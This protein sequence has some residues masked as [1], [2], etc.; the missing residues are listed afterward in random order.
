MYLP[1]VGN[2]LIEIWAKL[3]GNGKH[4][5]LVPLYS[6]TNKNIPTSP[7]FTRKQIAKHHHYAPLPEPET[8]LV[9]VQTTQTLFLPIN[10]KI[11]E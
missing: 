6:Q 8:Y 5:F 2:N 9:I 10:S 1:K 4:D 7:I 11:K 3:V